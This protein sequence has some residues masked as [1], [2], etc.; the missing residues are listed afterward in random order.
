[1]MIGDRRAAILNTIIEEY[2]RT[3]EPIG[4]KTLCQM[5]PYSISSATIRNEMAFLSNLGYLEQRHTSGGRVPSKESYRFY[6]NNLMAPQELSPYEMEKINEFLSVNASDPERLLTDAT[7]LLAEITHCAS[8]CSTIQDPLDCIQGVEL[9]PA[10]QNKA[11]LVMLSV[12]GK[13]KSSICK[14]ACPIDE[15]FKALFYE[16]VKEYFIGTPLTDISLSKLQSASISL[17]KRMF[18]MLPVLTSLCSL[19]NEATKSNVFVDGETNLLD[20]IEFGEDVY[21]ILSFLAGKVQ[22]KD[23]LSKYSNSNNTISLMIGDENYC[24]DLKNTATIVSKYKY[25]EAQKA[26]LGIIGST[27]ID[28]KKIIPRVQYVTSVVSGL[29]SKGGV[30]YE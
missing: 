4:S 21:K 19:C 16:V 11:M 20:H 28:Y 15:E 13:I 17:G 1:M 10:G 7:K 18:D 3:G 6:V 30:T 12:G 27:R 22:L 23:F 26:T 29:L 9:I 8:F 5:L 24:Y 14:T 2:I 25:N